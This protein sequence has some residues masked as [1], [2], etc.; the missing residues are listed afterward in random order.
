MPD[1]PN[2]EKLFTETNCLTAL[3]NLEDICKYLRFFKNEGNYQSFLRKYLP[4]LAFPQYAKAFHE[5]I[6]D[7]EDED[8]ATALKAQLKPD[9]PK[10]TE[11]VVTELPAE[12]KKTVKKI[13]KPS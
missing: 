2:I 3:S 5:F 12:P 1:G 6:G 9:Q 11:A 4:L 8:L 7:L 10:I 13:I